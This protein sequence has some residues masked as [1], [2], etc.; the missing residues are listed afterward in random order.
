MVTSSRRFRWA[1]CR[2]IVSRSE[3]IPRPGRAAKPCLQSHAANRS[4]IFYIYDLFLL[5]HAQSGHR[6]VS[7]SAIERPWYTRK[8]SVS[9]EDI[10]RNLRQA[11]WQEKIFGDPALDAHTRKILQ[12][13]AEWVKVAT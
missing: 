3:T 4:L 10:L 9:F 6:I 8:T 12:P 2:P 13:L 5:R 11:K 7:K 1:V